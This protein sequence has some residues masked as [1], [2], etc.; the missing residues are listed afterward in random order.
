MAL[1]KEAA[2]E[3]SK[4]Y[5]QERKDRRGGGGLLVYCYNVIVP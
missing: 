2:E 5:L 4:N 1:E 3:F